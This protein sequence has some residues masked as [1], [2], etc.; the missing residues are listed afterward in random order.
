M[1]CPIC[2]SDDISNIWVKNRMLQ[3]R[4][5]DCGWRG[6][7]R[8][9]EIIPIEFTREICVNQFYGWEYELFDKYGH[10]L[11]Y[12]KTYDK[13]ENL[14]KEL[15]AEMD[16]YNSNVDVAPVTAIIWPPSVTVLG[17]VYK[18]QSQEEG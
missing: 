3:C 16:R 17:E 12:S 6:N 7:P 13:K 5:R 8:V 11:I 1:E 10:V 18:K 15:N 2:K 4:C 9:P 14:L